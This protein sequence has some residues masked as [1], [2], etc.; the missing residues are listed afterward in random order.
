MRLKNMLGIYDDDD[1]DDSCS[2]R[3]IGNRLN[4]SSYRTSISLFEYHREYLS[5]HA[6]NLSEFIRNTID[7]DMEENGYDIGEQS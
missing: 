4:Y 2:D 3:R 5:S 1:D 7:N 6:I